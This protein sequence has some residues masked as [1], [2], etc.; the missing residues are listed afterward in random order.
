MTDLPDMVHRGERDSFRTFA[1]LVTLVVVVFATGGFGYLSL[2]RLAH[3]NSRLLT[4]V[5][6]EQNAGEASNRREI[7]RLSTQLNYYE[8]T[9]VPTMVAYME[10]LAKQVRSLGGNPGTLVIQPPSASLSP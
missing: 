6:N 10:K 2:N 8:S 3:S 1:A 7:A 9:V 5:R 4:E